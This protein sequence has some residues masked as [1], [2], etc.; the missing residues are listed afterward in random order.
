MLQQADDI[1]H[2]IN[3][4]RAHALSCMSRSALVSHRTARKNDYGNSE[5][6]CQIETHI[7]CMLY[8]QTLLIGTEIDIAADSRRI[9]LLR[10][11]GACAQSQSADGLYCRCPEIPTLRQAV[12]MLQDS[13]TS[14]ETPPWL[15]SATN[16]YIIIIYILYHDY[17]LQQLWPR[18]ACDA[19]TASQHTSTWFA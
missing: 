15:R 18:A 11:V 19:H 3:A 17:S 5:T 13:T 12:Q 10:C 4:I 16:I 6:V 8:T 1:T 14:S 7:L 9:S 2:S